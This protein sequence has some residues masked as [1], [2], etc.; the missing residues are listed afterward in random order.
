[1]KITLDNIASVEGFQH[2]VTAGLVRTRAH[3]NPSVPYIVYDYTEIAQFN[4]NWD[5]IT[6]A[7]RGLIVNTETNEIVAR[8]F[9]KFFNDNESVEG[10]NDFA[11]TG[12]V[13]VS[14]KVDGSLGIL[15]QLPNG[16]WAISTRGSMNSDQ[17][18]HATEVYNQ[19]YANSWTPRTDVTYLFEIIFRENRIVVDYGDMD[20]LVLLGAVHKATG[21]SLTVTEARMGWIGPVARQM[22]FASYEEAV[23]A[24][25]PDTEEG[26]IIHFTDTDKRVKVKGDT[27]LRLHRVV[28]GI[29]PLRVW[30]NLAYDDQRNDWILAIPEEFTTLVEKYEKAL[31]AQ[32]ETLFQE[33]VVVTEKV[34]QD[35][36]ALGVD[37]RKV[38]AN[39]INQTVTNKQLRGRVFLLVDGRTDTLRKA[40]WKNVRPFGKNAL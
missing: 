28:F 22:P 4:K 11:R 18:A 32:H 39:L 16:S 17:A 2:A 37:D 40:L 9:G 15:Y 3:D 12:P 23:M 7:S 35:Y 19:R 5:T 24:A 25:I 13:V 29:T 34:M 31:R 21:R 8:P 36:S 1:M 30:E 14:E 20:D 26:Y 38:L 27:Y 33:A 6:I 10:Y